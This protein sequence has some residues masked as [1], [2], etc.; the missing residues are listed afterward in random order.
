MKK[1]RVKRETFRWFYLDWT[2]RKYANLI[3]ERYLVQNEKHNEMRLLTI[4]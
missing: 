2:A 4:P 1:N 3:H